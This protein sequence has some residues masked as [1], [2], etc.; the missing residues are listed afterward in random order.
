M[1]IL[2][3]IETVE[4]EG[5]PVFETESELRLAPVG[6]EDMDVEVHPPCL[7]PVEFWRY[8]AV[9]SFHEEKDTI[10]MYT[11]TKNGNFE[12]YRTYPDSKTPIRYKGR[13]LNI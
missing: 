1:K 13:L 7:T 11:P 9:K 12:F 10:A 8:V 5:R 4:R 2:P 3:H 6:L